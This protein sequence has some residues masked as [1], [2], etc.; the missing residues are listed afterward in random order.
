MSSG[1]ATSHLD[2]IEFTTSKAMKKDK[3]EP[4]L[5][6]E[7]HFSISLRFLAMLLTSCYN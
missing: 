6:A 5:R 1:Q 7:P 2:I 3:M 4:A